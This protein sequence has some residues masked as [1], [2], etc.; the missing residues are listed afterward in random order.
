MAESGKKHPIRIVARRTGTP[1]TT[2]RAWER[3]Y[4]AVRPER[5]ETGRRLYSDKDVERLKLIRQAVDAGRA[6]SS[7]A[8]MSDSDLMQLIEED[9]ESTRGFEGVAPIGPSAADVVDAC[10]AAVGKTDAQ[11]LYSC[12]NRAT[13]KFDTGGLI[14]EV[15][16]P[17]LYRIGDSWKAGR[18][19][20]RHEHMASSVV[21]AIL[22]QLQARIH[23]TG[24]RTIV[25]GTPPGQLHDLGTQFAAAL[26]VSEGWNVVNLGADIPASEVVAAAEEVGAGIVGLSIV[27]PLDDARVEEALEYL[28]EHLGHDTQLIVGGQGVETYQ[29]SIEKAGGVTLRS[30]RDFARHLSRPS[31]THGR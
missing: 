12:L 8:R 17:L 29:A 31:P 24:P 2:L 10:F 28:G 15:I 22:T 14:D 5:A 4:G 21:R 13:V 11:T 1:E 3:R 18:L 19:S 23:H 7:V 9:R 6:V 20:P 16:T 26:A 30:A 25:L 27:H